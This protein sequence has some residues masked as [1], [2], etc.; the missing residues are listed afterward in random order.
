[1]FLRC[2]GYWEELEAV[3]YED[4]RVVETKSGRELSFNLGRESSGES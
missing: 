4:S 1:M 2:G 3:G